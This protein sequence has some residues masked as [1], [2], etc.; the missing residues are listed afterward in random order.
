V[1][2]GLV[3]VSTPIGNLGDMTARGIAALRE[4][5]IVLCE[6]TRVTRRL[7][8][9]FGIV[10]RLSALHEHNEE[11]RSPA[12][13]AALAAG[14]RVAL[15]SDAGTPVLSD[16]GFRLVRAAIA[17]GLPVSAVPGPNA[18]LMALTISG[19]PPTPFLF[20]G[21]PPPRGA[22]RRAAFARLAALERAGLA[23]TL[24]W[25]EAPHRLAATL[26]DLFSI[27]GAREAAIARELT[28]RFEE[29]RRGALPDLARHYSE[30]PPLG[31]ITLVL[32]PAGTE[33]AEVPAAGLDS[34]LAA[35]LAAGMSV[36][37]AIAAVAAETGAP[38]RE[39][40]ARALAL[41]DRR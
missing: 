15:V 10:A 29:V 2:A 24:V 3:L 27:F 8:G 12:I 22:A 18:A 31:E 7:L 6:D 28:K 9:A 13:L 37:E 14:R 19:L 32:G 40:Y 38:R 30:S 5:D 17:S 23:A 36:K 35:R 1:P 41:K 25:H 16:P 21:F 20:L 33:E 26:A 39:V 34:R 11:R 4:A